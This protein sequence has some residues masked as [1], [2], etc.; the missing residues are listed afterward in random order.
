[1]GWS[2]LGDRNSSGRFFFFG[3]ICVERSHDIAGR[4]ASARF[5]YARRDFY[6]YHDWGVFG[7]IPVLDWLWFLSSGCLSEGDIKPSQGVT[8]LVFDVVDVNYVLFFE[9]LIV[10]AIV[11]CICDLHGFRWSC[12]I[13]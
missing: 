4:G 9:H 6:G 3:V 2:L 1:M 10:D 7:A 13:V 8:P 12:C 5:P 11:A